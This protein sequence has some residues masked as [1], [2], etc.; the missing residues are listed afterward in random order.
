MFMR[1]GVILIVR[2]FFYFY[3]TNSLQHQHHPHLHLALADAMAPVVGG[4]QGG[5]SRRPSTNQRAAS[6]VATAQPIR[7]CHGEKGDPRDVTTP[8]A[9]RRTCHS[10]WPLGKA[11]SDSARQNQP[12]RKDIH[13]DTEVRL[14][15]G[16]GQKV[17][18]RFFVRGGFS[19]ERWFFFGRWVS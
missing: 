18:L 11:K 9:N 16:G 1:C 6:E 10:F 13:H 8:R 2:V 5:A 4:V 19:F 14:T 15:E 17:R 7:P 3:T 12:M